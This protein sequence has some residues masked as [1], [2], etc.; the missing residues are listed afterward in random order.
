M[1]YSL[2]KDENG[3]KEGYRQLQLRTEAARGGEKQAEREAQTNLS[4]MMEDL[5][6]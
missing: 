4:R 5:S 1:V 6:A 2:F 3:E